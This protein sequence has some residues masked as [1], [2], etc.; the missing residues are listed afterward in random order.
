MPGFVIGGQQ[1][2]VPGTNLRNFKD[3]P[4]FTLRMPNDGRLRN[5]TASG[6]WHWIRGLFLHVTGG[7]T[8]KEYVEHQ[9]DHVLPGDGPPGTGDERILNSWTLSSSSGGAQL[10]VDF[11]RSAICTCDLLTDAAYAQTSCNENFD[12]LEMLRGSKDGVMYAGQLDEV[13]KFCDAFTR[14][15]GVQRQFHAPY[16]AY[17][18][19]P[20]LLAGGSDCVGL[21][22]HRDQ[23]DGRGPLDPGDPIYDRLAAAGY[24]LFDYSKDEDLDVWKARQLELQLMGCYKGAIDGVCGP[25]TVQGLLD[26]GYPHGLWVS[27][28]GD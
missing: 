5:K 17:H 9:E 14:L 19:V 3:D 22:G 12:A 26:A 25:G 24:E 1:H 4:R 21:F 8:E 7:P 13:V 27:R 6:K 28:P 11:D 16:R 18:P 15:M 23:T 20:R 2:E 10:I